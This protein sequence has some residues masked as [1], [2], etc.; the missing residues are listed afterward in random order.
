MDLGNLYGRMVELMKG[1]GKMGKC[2]GKVY[3]FG[4]MGENIKVSTLM[5]RNMEMG[6]FIGLMVRFLKVLG[7]MGRDKVKE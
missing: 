5:I 3:I 6:N 4:R 7:L 1:N 2:M